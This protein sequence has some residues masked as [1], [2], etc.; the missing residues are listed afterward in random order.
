MGG[1]KFKFTH[2]KNEER[3]KYEKKQQHE[4]LQVSTP[5]ISNSVPEQSTLDAVDSL[6]VSVP[7]NIV[8]EGP[9]SSVDTLRRRLN[10]AGVLPSGRLYTE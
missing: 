10:S 7:I 4:K 9:V 5:L 3:K 6:L 8:M 2:R 1:R